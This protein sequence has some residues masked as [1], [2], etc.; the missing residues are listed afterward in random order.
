MCKQCGL[1]CSFCVRF[2]LFLFLSWIPVA[3]LIGSAREF[4][5]FTHPLWCA[6]SR[7][8]QTLLD[9]L[10]AGLNI[11]TCVV[12]AHSRRPLLAALLVF[13]LI[14]RLKSFA[15][16]SNYSLVSSLE[17]LTVSIYAYSSPS[18]HP[19]LAVD[20]RPLL[21]PIQ[22]ASLNMPNTVFFACSFSERRHASGL[23]RD[24]QHEHEFPRSTKVTQSAWIEQHALKTSLARP[25]GLLWV[26]HRPWP[27]IRESSISTQILP[28]THDIS[29]SDPDHVWKHPLHCCRYVSWMR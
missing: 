28:Q 17:C 12:F 26:S 6:E 14:A 16:F 5:G 9:C 19:L 8:Q 25:W 27:T 10:L 18:R 24:N 3:F 13:C 20:L 21:K 7:D 15:W 11:S 22:H 4:P 1:S 2:G 29:W 23:P